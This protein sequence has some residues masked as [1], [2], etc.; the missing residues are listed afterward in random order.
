MTHRLRHT[1]A[2]PEDFVVARNTEPGTSL[3]YLLR[4]PLGKDGIILK[5]KETWPRTS[6]VYCHRIE[7]WPRD[8]EV[9][10]RVP[11]RSCVRRGAAIDLVLDRG[12]EN[13]SQLVFTRIR[14][15]RQAIFWQTARTSKQARP[16]VSLPTARAA[17]IPDLE[18][19]VDSHERYPYTFKD[20][21]VIT[22][23]AGLAAGDYGIVVHGSLLASVERKSLPDLVSSLTTGKL[24]YQMADLSAVPRAAVVV[25]DRYSQIFRNEHVRPSIVA[26]R[27][28]ECQVNWPAVPVL[29]LETRPLAQEWTYRFLAAARAGADLERG[30]ERVLEDLVRARPLAPAP[31][32][33]AEVRAWAVDQGLPVSAKGRIPKELVDAFR[34][35]RR[36]DG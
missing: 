25:E 28:A 24:K 15:G 32:T 8:A 19:V 22:R 30:G 9:V 14:G 17:G 2:M 7:E 5:A 36:Q 16:A 21:Q 20:Q 12:R 18:I 33:A 13:R 6:K 4:I 34:A 1:G 35:A 10:E 29:F 3:P 23:R 31:P 11:T 26:D 27:L